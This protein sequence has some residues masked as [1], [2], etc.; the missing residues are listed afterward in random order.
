ME[1]DTIDKQQIIGLFVLY[2]ILFAIYKIKISHEI[3]KRK[4]K[5]MEIKE[6]DKIRN[7]RKD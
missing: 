1:M 4:E 5:E 2:V 6:Y 7:K 3:K